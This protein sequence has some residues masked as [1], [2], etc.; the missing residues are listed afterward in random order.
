MH[1]D[2]V[3]PVRCSNP[4]DFAWSELRKFQN[5]EF[6]ERCIF[7]LH[8]L[9]RRWA[10]NVRKQAIQIRQCLLQAEEY[11]TASKSV[12]LATKP[13]LL[14]YSILS[15]ALAEIL[16]KQ[17]GASSLDKMRQEHRHHGLTFSLGQTTSNDAIEKLKGL[18]AKPLINNGLRLGTFEIW[19]RS[20]REMPAIG[21]QTFIYKNLNATTKRIIQLFMPDNSRLDLVPK[22]GVD[23]H[24]CLTHYPSFNLS[25]LDSR[26]SP[27]IV[28]ASIEQV[29]VNQETNKTQIKV[30]PGRTSDI[31][32]FIENIK[33]SP[34]IVN[35]MNIKKLPSG[36]IIE[37]TEDSINYGHQC[38]LPHCV[39]CSESYSLFYPYDVPYNEFGLTYL[40]LF[41]SGSYARYYP[42]HWIKD[43]EGNSIIAHSI[44][45]FI[46]EAQDRML[47]LILSELSRIYYVSEHQPF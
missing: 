34:S 43:I 10:Q 41:I 3:L 22:N 14:Y 47:L 39:L 33:L 42:D 13:V 5:I 11:H 40:I 29:I 4:C 21:N 32:E 24:E 30:H 31:D 6:T 26:L 28:R 23:L 17:S 12:S 25:F 37:W 7:R 18:R 45:R 35:I 19:H 44:S 1:F 16:M 15:L 8:K 2:S 27:R 38:K 20:A 46:D 9:D 36:Y